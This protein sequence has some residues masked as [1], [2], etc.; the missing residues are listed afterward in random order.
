[1]LRRT[2]WAAVLLATIAALAQAQGVTPVAH[3]E[4]RGDG[5]VHLLLV[6]ELACDWTAWAPFMERN[7]DQYTMVAVTLPGMAGTD[8]PPDPEGTLVGKGA[9]GTPWLDNAVDALL[10]VIEEQGLERPVVVG[11]SLGAL[12]GFRLAL[13]HPESIGGLVAL[14][15]AP[16]TIVYT[17][18]LARDERTSIVQRNL[19][20]S[21]GGAT[22][23][24]WAQRMEELVRS[25][26]TDEGRADELAA[27]A[28]RTTKGPGL[29][30]MVEYHGTD[31]TPRL[32]EVFTPV[33]VLAAAGDVPVQRV[34]GE[35]RLRTAW[36]N[37]LAGL[38]DLELVFVPGA[39]HF[40]ADDAPEETDRLIAR[41][42]ERMPEVEPHGGAG[43]G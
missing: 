13:E 10:A 22:P 41:F 43:G 9:F 15:G 7:A 14:D 6:P 39:R 3:A 40:V 18:P 21:L 19:T 12:L 23:E 2:V 20:H 4:R 33:L 32:R 34:R 8:P 16:T 38:R 31:L 37:H 26:V 28:V 35:E 27:V 30:Y 24:Q 11:H 25:G 36:Y 29:R 42:V 1:M 17:R 5:P